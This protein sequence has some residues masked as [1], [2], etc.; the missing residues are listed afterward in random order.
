MVVGK[1]MGITNNY[2]INT[3]AIVALHFMKNPSRK[4]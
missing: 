2:D 4:D 1:E 3:N